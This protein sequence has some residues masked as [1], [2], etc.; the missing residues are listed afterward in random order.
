MQFD[1]SSYFPQKTFLL[2]MDEQSITDWAASAADSAMHFFITPRFTMEHSLQVRTFVSEGVGT[3]RTIVIFFNVFSPDAAQVLLKALEEPDMDTAVI[4]ATP[5]PYVVPQT[6]RSRVVLLLGDTT[7]P[8][9]GPAMA[10]S[11]QKQTALGYCKETFTAESD[12]DAA[13]KRAK[14]ISFLDELEVQFRTDRQKVQ[15]VFSAKNML[16]KANM[17]VKYVIEYAITAVFE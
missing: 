6:I 17:P 1:L 9:D 14:A 16:F 3:A 15:S 5:H 7:A 12:D 8:K 10:T 13:L 4:L 11:W 2:Q